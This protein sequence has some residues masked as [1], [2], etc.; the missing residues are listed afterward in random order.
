[1]VRPGQSR[2]L[3]HAPFQVQVTGHEAGQETQTQVEKWRLKDTN[4]LDQSNLP[5]RCS[6]AL[7]TAH[8]SS[9]PRLLGLLPSLAWDPH[10]VTLEVTHRFHQSPLLPLFLDLWQDDI[11]SFHP[12]G[13]VPMWSTDSSDR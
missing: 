4:T 10:H 11:F 12:K 2:G 13:D 8:P 6:P 3:C 7:K 5:V 1:M 9:L